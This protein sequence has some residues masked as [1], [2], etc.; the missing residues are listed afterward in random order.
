MILFNRLVVRVPL[1]ILGLVLLAWTSS[2]A[3]SSGKSEEVAPVPATA[4]ASTDKCSATTN[5]PYSQNRCV[6]QIDRDKPYNPLAYQLPGGTTAIIEISNARRTESI[7][8]NSTTEEIA[9]PDVL[10]ALVKQII[11]PLKSLTLTAGG[12]YALTGDPINNEQQLVSNQLAVVATAINKA[13]AELTCLQAYVAVKDEQ[14][15]LSCSQDSL[16]EKTFE[17]ARKRLIDD[18]SGENGASGLL[19]PVAR[20]KSIDKE[21]ADK[22]TPCLPQIDLTK[23]RTSL[24]LDKAI[25]DREKCINDSNTLLWNQ[26]RLNESLTALQSAQ[27][28]LLQAN[29]I[30]QKIPGPITVVRYSISNSANR[31]STIKIAAKNLLSNVTTDVATVSI[32]WQGSSWVVSTG[33]LFSD[34][35]N[36]TFTNAPIIVNGQPLLDSNGKVLTIVTEN[37]S[38]PS[39]IFPMVFANYRI[40]AFSR[41]KWE[42]KCPGGCAFLVTGGIGA[43][44]STK[45][46]DFA[47]GLSFQIGSVLLTPSVDIGRQLQLSNGVTIGQKLGSSPPALP[48]ENKWGPHFGFA[49]TYRLPI[50]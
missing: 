40:G 39:V 46:T 33:I 28:T 49:L 12:R 31:H 24:E 13:T 38:R 45:S 42:A 8:F 29:D 16:A 17:D 19:L 9:K 6:V 32:I 10:G 23:T 7:Q 2:L 5:K 18:I 43:N 47:A 25:A 26:N 44:L 37:N 30:L 21:I 36:R 4:A 1:T 35:P 20:I 22:L 41:A 27:K 14:G 11:E 34:L 15:V 48:T 3:Q 50:T